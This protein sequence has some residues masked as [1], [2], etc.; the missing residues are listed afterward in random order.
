VTEKKVVCAPRW[1][2]TPFWRW[3]RR[4]LEKRQRSTA[5]FC[6]ELGTPRGYAAVRMVVFRYTP[7][8]PRACRR[9]GTLPEVFDERRVNQVLRGIF[10]SLQRSRRGVGRYDSELGVFATAT[11]SVC[12]SPGALSVKVLHRYKLRSWPGA[13]PSRGGASA[14]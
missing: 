10:T 8:T 7:A 12:A 1:L 6:E 14:I 3:R 13:S 2:E 4:S 11:M 9:C 5:R